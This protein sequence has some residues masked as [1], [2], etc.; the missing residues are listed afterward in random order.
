MAKHPTYGWQV[1]NHKRFDRTFDVIAIDF[2]TTFNKK[3]FHSPALLINLLAIKE[4]PFPCKS[5]DYDMELILFVGRTSLTLMYIKNFE[6][7]V[8]DGWW[9]KQNKEA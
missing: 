5:G 4:Y 7:K 2:Q 3:C 9:I 8:S 6:K 1:L